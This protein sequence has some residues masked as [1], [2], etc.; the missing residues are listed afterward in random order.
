MQMPKAALYM[1][2]SPRTE[3]TYLPDLFLW[4]IPQEI[5]DVAEP[6]EARDDTDKALAWPL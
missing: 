5:W 6:H 4:R 1:S 2:A 3:G